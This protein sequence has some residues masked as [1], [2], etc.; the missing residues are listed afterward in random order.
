M[1]VLSHIG[2][3]AGVRCG[4]V[5]PAPT[6]LRGAAWRMAAA[7]RAASASRVAQGVA[8][9]ARLDQGCGARLCV[10]AVAAGA[11]P[12][13]RRG[14]VV[15]TA[16][17]EA[18]QA[19]PR[20][21]RAGS[22][23]ERVAGEAGHTEPSKRKRRAPPTGERGETT[24]DGKPKPDERTVAD[25]VGRGWFKTEEA[26]V[27]LLTR[28]QS[29][30][31]RYAFETAEP[32][33]DWLEATL[34]PEPVKDGLCP[35]AKAV[36][37]DPSL[38]YKDAAALQ[39]K[40][41]A[42][43]LPT[44]AGGA[45][46]AF[47]TEQARE[48]VRKHPQ[49]LGYSVETYKASWSMLTAAENGLGLSPEEARKCILHSPRILLYDNDDVLRRVKVLESLG[50]A[51]AREMLLAESRV[52]NYKDE[53]VN[54]HAAWW[55]Q[56]GLDHVKL[57]TMHANLLGAPKVAELQAK[58]DF[59]GRV[60]GMSIA[61]LNNAGSL[62]T[63]SLDGRLRTRY[64]YALHKHR[65]ARFGSINTMIQKTDATFLAMMQ[66]GTSSDRASK[67]EVARYQKLVTSAGFVAWRERQEARILHGSH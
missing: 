31:S 57:V 63:R 33:A 29:T 61:D 43:T 30:I 26:A 49:L 62:F 66:G 44:A 32:A 11:E 39:R 12:P 53:T 18:V 35:A 54:E 51:E 45:G 3:C 37:R 52:L 20:A 21:R 65:L 40:W 15:A 36:K 4:A 9:R 22:A 5:R 24:E 34:G 48:A 58:L 8:R 46:I 64:F 28:A 59:L 10:A 47:S 42:L 6:Q 17:N 56:T 41:V 67:A 7:L 14:R 60:A 19:E 27:A 1:A 16:D 38:L 50:Y 23:G 55:K 13:R 25:L 2:M